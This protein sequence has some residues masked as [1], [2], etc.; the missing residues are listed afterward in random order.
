MRKATKLLTLVLAAL[1]IMSVVS[2]PASAAFTDVSVENEALYEAVEL[3]ST[4]NIAKGTTETTFGPDELVTRQQMAAFIFRLMKAGKSI[5][6]GTNETTFADL[7]DATF[8][9]MISWAN[10]TGVITGRNATT[11]DPKGNITLQDAYT[12]LVRALG[13]EKDEK[14]PYPFGYINQAE[15]LGLDENLPSSVNYGDKLTRGDVAILLANAF[16]AD[17]N[18]VISEYGWI[19]V[20]T[21]RYEQL[22][23]PN[24]NAFVNGNEIVEYSYVLKEEVATVAKDIFGVETEKFL[25]TATANTA[26]LGNSPIKT[27]QTQDIETIKGIRYDEDGYQIHG[28]FE[29]KF[30]DLGLEGKS[31]DYL[32]DEITLFVKK[33]DKLA[34]DE[35]VAAKSNLIKKT[36][37]AKDVVIDRSVNEEKEYYV[38]GVKDPEALKTMTGYVEFAGTKAYLDGTNAPYSYKQLSDK[39][40]NQGLINKAPVQFL[41]LSTIA[42]DTVGTRFSYTTIANTNFNGTLTNLTQQQNPAYDGLDKAFVQYLPRVYAGGL[43]EL[44]VYDSNGDGYAEY[45]IVKNY[46]AYKIEDANGNRVKL[47][48]LSNNAQA[49]IENKNI[50][51][52]GD[53]KTNAN[54]LVFAKG[55]TNNLVDTKYIEVKAGLD[56]VDSTV[57]SV[58]NEGTRPNSQFVDYTVTLKSGEKL[59]SVDAN[60]KYNGYTAQYPSVPGTAVKFLVK[61]GIIV[62]GLGA[63]AGTFDTAANYG[64]VLP[65]TTNVANKYTNPG[66]INN[67]A[68]G[69]T[70]YVFEVSGVADGKFVSQ[71]F[72]NVL[73]DGKVVA[74]KLADSIYTKVRYSNN[75]YSYNANNTYE[76][77][78]IAE[79]NNISEATLVEAVLQ[80]EYAN[81]IVTYT[82]GANNDFVLK[83]LNLTG[84]L[85]NAVTEDAV[86]F[87]ATNAVLKNYANTVY[88]F[89][90]QGGAPV[91]RINMQNYSKFIVETTDA[92]TGKAVYTVYTAETLPKF[93]ASTFTTMYGIL[94]NNTA[95]TTLENV[96]I[97]YGKTNAQGLAAAGTKNLQIVVGSTTRAT[98]AGTE[99]VLSLLDPKT[100]T[101]TNDVVAT[102]NVQNAAI[103][104][105]VELRDDGKAY[106]YTVAQDSYSAANMFETTFSYGNDS[107]DANSNFLT[108][109]A[110]AN[111]GNFVVNADTTYLWFTNKNT[112]QMVDATILDADFNPY[113]SALGSGA[114]GNFQVFVVADEN[115]NTAMDQSIKVVKTIIVTKAGTDLAN[116]N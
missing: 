22:W 30:A 73:V 43:A 104:K 99:V 44:D 54:V 3:L 96:G 103:G 33:A 53:Y 81:K 34:D 76:A 48:A 69:N 19:S 28:N 46:D 95:S 31:D 4:L 58:V 61:D 11:F 51:I 14:L 80:A 85:T 106:A 116:A 75:A 32:L 12:M 100:A 52:K 70:Q 18:K 56:T 38:G 10:Q 40:N 90:T 65:Y 42:H 63:T 2:I 71:L 111:A 67:T 60:L 27:S 92:N 98:T 5:E 112:Y 29:F 108:L 109:N 55:T 24:Q 82:A 23:D 84:N 74:V 107:Y 66:I 83:A 47:T 39:Y 87:S 114:N 93:T 25:V 77:L 20:G 7:D 21:G 36:V 35:I 9:Y 97:I 50:V 8:Y 49:Y 15:E 68:F 78:E 17:M 102:T 16:Y 62:A 13:Y 91:A 101:V 41:E 88:E 79:R 26:A 115:N 37:A 94:V 45:V 110:I 1:M 64:I 6:G 105:V 113:D 89:T 72:V 86:A 57:Y 59:S